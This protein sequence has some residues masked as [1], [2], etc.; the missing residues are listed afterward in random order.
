MQLRFPV[1]HA[2]TSRIVH[3]VMESVADIAKTIFT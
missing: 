1:I 2:E 3:I